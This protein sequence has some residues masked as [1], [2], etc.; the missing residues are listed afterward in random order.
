MNVSRIQP[1]VLHT[2]PSGCSLSRLD[3]SEE[4][5]VGREALNASAGIAN[6]FH[7]AMPVESKPET[8]LDRVNEHFMVSAINRQMEDVLVVS[9]EE[10][11]NSNKTLEINSYK[12][13]LLAF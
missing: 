8:M 7:N 11:I 9:F 1:V 5:A 10:E 2:I 6:G 13:L 4:R 12:T 3:D